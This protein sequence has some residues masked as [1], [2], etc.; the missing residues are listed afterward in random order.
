VSCP[1][2]TADTDFRIVNNSNED[3]LWTFSFRDKTYNSGDLEDWQNCPWTTNVSGNSVGTIED[4]KSSP[5]Y[6]KAGAIMEDR[7]KSHRIKE[8]LSYGWM[9]YY[10]FNYDSVATIPWSRIR[11]E[12]IILKEVTFHSWEEMESCNFTITYP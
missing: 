11:D 2:D 10:L 3:I 8:I 5:F 12:R 7:L 9:K 1:K 4:E 6:I